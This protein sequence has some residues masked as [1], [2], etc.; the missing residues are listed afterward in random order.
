[1]FIIAGLTPSPIVKLPPQLTSG[2][3]PHANVLAF[4]FVVIEHCA[5]T[6]KVQIDEKKITI[7]TVKTLRKNSFVFKPLL[8]GTDRFM[9][10]K[11]SN[12]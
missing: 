12:C 1:M 3:V 11:F 10:K 8:D 2:K 9:M 6:C 4:L 7:K 5:E